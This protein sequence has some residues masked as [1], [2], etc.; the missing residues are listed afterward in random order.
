M[1]GLV[2]CTAIE[3][4][5]QYD[6]GACLVSL[7]NA[8]IR[9]WVLTGDKVGTAIM[10]GQACKRIERGHGGTNEGEGKPLENRISDETKKFKR[11]GGERE[12]GSR[13]RAT[14]KRRSEDCEGIGG[15]GQQLYRAT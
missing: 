13:Y 4:K 5:L 14:A 7:S 12:F 9:T 8:N 6:V 10:I 3:D 11:G 15:V 2:G 1:G